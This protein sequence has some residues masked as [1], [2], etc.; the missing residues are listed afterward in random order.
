MGP[1]SNVDNAVKILHTSN[2]VA[3][4]YINH[5]YEL[6]ATFLWLQTGTIWKNNKPYST[7]ISKSVSGGAWEP[8]EP[9]EFELYIL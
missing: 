9:F 4:A 3:Q 5:G 6:N 8:T 2:D 1:R 7:F